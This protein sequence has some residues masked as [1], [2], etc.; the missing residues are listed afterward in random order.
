MP[1][2]EEYEIIELNK[3]SSLERHHLDF[4]L[5]NNILFKYMN[6]K[7]SSLSSKYKFELEWFDF[8]SNNFAISDVS[9]IKKLND[10]FQEISKKSCSSL[11]DSQHIVYFFYIGLTEHWILVIYDS[12]YKNN[13]LLFDSYSE[14]DNI[15]NLK[16]LDTDEINAFID[17]I[18]QK[19]KKFKKEPL[20]EYSTKQFIN[21][22]KDNQRILY[23]LNN[24]IVKSDKAFS[25]STSIVEE[26]CNSFM[27]SFGSLKFN[28]NDKLNKLLIIYYWIANEYHPKRIKEDFLDIM[29]ELGINSKDCDNE[30]I[31]LKNLKM[32]KLI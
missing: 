13:F 27:E 22:I 28:E 6:T 4:I 31:Y 9:N 3:E 17:G 8:I 25:L 1:S 5:K 23:K 26:R 24:L 19:I 29:T 7:Y 16:Y 2:L 11:S 18:N 12:F 21:H 20:N 32:K 15:F 10:I 30:I 14:T